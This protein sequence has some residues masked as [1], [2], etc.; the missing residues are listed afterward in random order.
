MYFGRIIAFSF[1]LKAGDDLRVSAL[2]LLCF[3]VP[4]D[5]ILAGFIRYT[6]KCYGQK[7]V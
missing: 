6:N 5:N 4:T 7:S 1:S 3:N 2:Q